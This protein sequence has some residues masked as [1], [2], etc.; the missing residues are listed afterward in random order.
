MRRSLGMLAWVSSSF[1]LALI[2]CSFILAPS[3]P[4][5][6]SYPPPGCPGDGCDT[7]CISDTC[8]NSGCTGGKCLCGSTATNC[9]K[10]GCDTKKTT[11]GCTN[12]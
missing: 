7:T 3:Q 2:V 10:C 6:A 4:V 12:A 5:L 8:F 9:D 11:C 1:G